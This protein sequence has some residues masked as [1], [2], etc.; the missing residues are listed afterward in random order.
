MAD[1]AALKTALESDS[2]YDA[3]VRSGNN[4]ELLRLGLE[5]KAGS[6]KVWDDISVVDFVDAYG[7]A[8]IPA[9]VEARLQLIAGEDGT[10]PTS[11]PGIRAW[12]E[13]GVSATVKTALQALA[14]REQTWFE[15]AGAGR[16]T[17]NDIREAVRQ[18]AKSFIVTT[19][20]A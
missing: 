3:N 2:R 12:F 15:D 5:T 17:L 13:S 14:E 10:V 9:N 18:I 16:V 6:A 1:Q 11:K 8:P 4:G 20:Q 19:G 7:T